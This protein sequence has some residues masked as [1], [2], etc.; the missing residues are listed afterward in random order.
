[1]GK[2]LDMLKAP[3]TSENETAAPPARRRRDLRQRLCQRRVLA[4]KS[5]P[6][7]LLP[8]MAIRRPACA[9]RGLILGL[10]LCFGV[11]SVVRFTGHC[12]CGLDCRACKG[13]IDAC[14]LVERQGRPR[15][16]GLKVFL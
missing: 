3:V 11:C 14:L 1:M 5:P 13:L 6:I 15:A 4:G 8:L 7:R 10:C 2:Q 9:A 16:L 12:C